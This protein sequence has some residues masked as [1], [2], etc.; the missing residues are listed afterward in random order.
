MLALHAANIRP[1]AGEKQCDYESMIE[2]DNSVV[3]GTFA[4]NLF[5]YS[6]DSKELA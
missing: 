5:L 2:I 6:E 3:V 1:A 4:A